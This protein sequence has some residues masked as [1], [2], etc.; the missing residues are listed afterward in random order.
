MNLNTTTPLRTST[1]QG[2]K[3]SGIYLKVLKPA[4]PLSS[5]KLEASLSLKACLLSMADLSQNKLVGP[6]NGAEGS[7]PYT[8]KCSWKSQP[9]DSTGPWLK[10]LWPNALRKVT[11]FPATDLSQK[12]FM[13]ACDPLL[14]PNRQQ[15]GE[16]DHLLYCKGRFFM[17]FY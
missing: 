8:G 6:I 1:P 13:V 11:G 3:E 15:R 12:W 2:R 9:Q 17:Y 7:N 14:Q 5:T 4:T 10:N 16:H